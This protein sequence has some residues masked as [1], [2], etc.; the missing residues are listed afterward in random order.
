[1]TVI[2]LEINSK[3]SPTSDTAAK[4]QLKIEVSFTKNGEI[5]TNFKKFIKK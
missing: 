4:S 1:M 5:D 2:N 3:L